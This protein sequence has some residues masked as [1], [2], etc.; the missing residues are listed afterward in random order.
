MDLKIVVLNDKGYG[1]KVMGYKV[2][3]KGYGFKVMGYKVSYEFI[4]KD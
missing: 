3:D 4:I 2:R 1:F